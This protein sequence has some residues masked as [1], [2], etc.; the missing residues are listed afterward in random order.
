MLVQAIFSRL[1]RFGHFSSRSDAMSGFL[2]CFAWLRNEFACTTA[3]LNGP[4]A[5]LRRLQP[6]CRRQ[7]GGQPRRP[8][9]ALLCDASP[10]W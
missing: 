10:D 5:G 6:D 2:E 4:S 3:S 8:A 9:R 1:K 7:G